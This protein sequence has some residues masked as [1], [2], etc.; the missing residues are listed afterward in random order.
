[1]RWVLKEKKKMKVHPL[2]TA[3]NEKIPDGK[4]WIAK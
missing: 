4:P 2:M 3:T 1:M